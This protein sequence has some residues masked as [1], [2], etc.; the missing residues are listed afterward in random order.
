[1]K[2]FFFP[3]LLLSD[4]H[5]LGGDS[6]KNYRHSTSKSSPNVHSKS[7]YGTDVNLL[8]PNN[9]PNYLNPT[10]NS[11]IN[12]IINDEYLS[13][14][15]SSPSLHSPKQARH[16]RESN[17][18]YFEHDENMNFATPLINKQNCRKKLNNGSTGKFQISR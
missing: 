16:K 11:K 3:I 17:F 2:I 14:R 6:N 1:M 5:I 13:I 12:F 10:Y 4:D 9:N 7:Y 15:N 18:N 8:K